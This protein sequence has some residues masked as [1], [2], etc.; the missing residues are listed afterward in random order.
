MASVIL[1]GNAGTLVHSDGGLPGRLVSG[2]DDGCAVL[3]LGPGSR[4]TP[5]PSGKPVK[6]DRTIADDI[7]VS[8]TRIWVVAGAVHD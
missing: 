3:A 7:S 5:R 6:S 2:D 8:H 4:T 1:H